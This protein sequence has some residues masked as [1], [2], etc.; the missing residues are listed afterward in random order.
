MRASDGSKRR[1]KRTVAP[2]Q[3]ERCAPIS[4]ATPSQTAMVIVSAIG[5]SFVRGPM[6]TTVIAPPQDPSVAMVAH[7]LLRAARIA[8]ASPTEMEWSD[9]A[10]HVP[11][12]L[13]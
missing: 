10:R 9:G 3:L 6:E 11:F 8:S 1:W 4:P 12:S 5:G 7:I 13:S 2:C